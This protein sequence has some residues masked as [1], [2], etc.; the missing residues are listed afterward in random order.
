MNPS[1][2][3]ARQSLNSEAQGMEISDEDGFYK[4]TEGGSSS[5]PLQV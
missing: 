4:G 1:A 2:E 5:K 3:C